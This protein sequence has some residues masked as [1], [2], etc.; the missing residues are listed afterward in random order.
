MARNGCLQ[1]RLWVFEEGDLAYPGAGFRAS[2]HVK[3]AIRSPEIIPGYFR[4]DGM[5]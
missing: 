3:I 4:V 1:Q 2:T 5:T